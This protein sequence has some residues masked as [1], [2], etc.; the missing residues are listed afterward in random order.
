MNIEKWRHI[1]DSKDLVLEQF[2]STCYDHCEAPN[3]VKSGKC[4]H[5]F[6]Y[7]LWGHVA[8]RSKEDTCNTS[9]LNNR[10]PMFLCNISLML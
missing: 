3:C 5:T 7:L 9:H 4:W 2:K 6:R 10:F 8:L 1:F